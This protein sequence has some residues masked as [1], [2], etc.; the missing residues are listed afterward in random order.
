MSKKISWREVTIWDEDGNEVLDPETKRELLL[1]Y[2]RTGGIFQYW[3]ADPKT[4]S[5][6]KELA[7]AGP[8]VDEIDWTGIDD[9]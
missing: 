9:Q 1:E 8:A 2:H 4:I 3:L 6:G 5:D 7:E